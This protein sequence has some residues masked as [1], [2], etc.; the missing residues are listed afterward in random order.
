ME[1]ERIRDEFS[2]GIV[3]SDLHSEEDEFES[4]V[5]PAHNTGRE[6]GETGPAAG[7]PPVAQKEKKK[8]GRRVLAVILIVLLSAGAGFGGGLAAM[9]YGQSYL[10][11]VP[12][13]NITITRTTE[14]YSEAIA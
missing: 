13:N 7:I 11:Q 6:A 14:S 8:T 5:Y 4:M 1:R 12:A 3:D 2:N 9:Y 10:G